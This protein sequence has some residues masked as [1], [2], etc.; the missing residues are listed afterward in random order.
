MT[1]AGLEHVLDHYIC[2][3]GH[4][5]QPPRENPWLEA[6]E[7]Q[8]D[9]Y[10]FHDWNERITAECYAPNTRARIL[11]D[12][13][14]I[15]RLVNNYARMSFNLGPTLLAWMRDADPTTY[16][17]VLDADR[18]SAKRFG[19]HGSAMA[20]VYGHA[21]MP[22]ADDRDRRTQVRW[23]VI[24]FQRRFGRDPDGMWLAE[25]AVDD[26][27]LELLAEAGIR[28]TVL[29]PHQAARSRP[30]GEERW[31]DVGGGR[32]DPTRPYRVT[33]PSGRQI[34][35]FFYDGPISQA[36]AFEGLLASADRFERRLMDGFADREG[37]QLVHIATDGESYGHHHR[38]GEMALAATLERIQQRDDVQL[39][40]YA[41]Y[42]SLFPPDHEAEI[43]QASSWS[44]SHGV[45]RW[46]SDCGCGSQPGR[47]QRWRA[48][49]R[50]ALGELR[51]E[52]AERYERTAAP[53][54]DDPWVARDDY[55][56]VVLDR[57]GQ[58]DAFLA[59]HARRTL[60]P[61]AT[62]RVLHLLEMQRHS[63]LMD[64][65]CGWFFDEL[66]RIEPVQV[67]RYAARAIQLAF[68]LTG[69][70]L[71]PRFLATLATAESNE[72]AYRDG[73]R[74]YE[75]QVR[76]A[77]ADLEQVGAHFAIASIVREHAA[78]ERVGAFEIESHD[79]QLHTAGRA[80]LA[81]GRLRVR[82]VVTRAEQHL[83]F[84]VLHL[85]D[86][87]FTCRV[88]PWGDD[89]AY[90]RLAEALEDRFDVADLPSVIRT[91]DEH[92]GAT[93][94]SLGTLFRDEQ[95]H[96]LDTVL[97]TTLDELESTYRTIY[98]GRAPLMRFLTDIDANLPTA[99]RSAAEVV[100]NAELTAQLATTDL[101]PDEVRSLLDEAERFG[102]ELDI[103]GLSHTFG[104]T[105]ARMTRRVGDHLADTDERFAHLDEQHT[106]MLNR[107]RTLL[108]VTAIVPFEV[109]LATAQ[110]VLWEALHDHYAD[111][112]GRAHAG[113]EIAQRWVQ[114]LDELAEA[115][116]VAPPAGSTRL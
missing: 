58:L 77:V 79:H 55:L 114:E 60:D 101:D 105:I 25:T 109:D 18:H 11:D 76:P 10:P 78:V 82:S 64:T 104:T 103:D 44:C 47:H 53:L 94:Y 24:D 62:S 107:A 88:R 54:L 61:D 36:V 4:F 75:R 19:G 67:L 6:V 92:L 116:R 20:Q 34:T 42:L 93:Q 73:R 17:D 35:V 8:D 80:Q 41:Q 38:H 30:I 57:D 32:V 86:H 1:G 66:S 12:H 39:T 15:T 68:E 111:V 69:E 95:Q 63:L 46:R 7:R 14:R 3:H 40:N 70:D 113:D 28:F 96:I 33:L 51:T 45:E 5:Y 27:T 29:S 110:D 91:I 16:R 115:I 108:E 22:L 65:S 74:L 37:P 59:R 85:G 90:Q 9:A 106:G 49:L 43:I 31:Q 81:Y 21:I 48:P 99:L 112:V 71:E 98:R 84:G 87:N 56:E 72:P 26:A 50:A 83:E 23:G 13:G 52:L 97:A 102:I 89:E 100:I 2:V